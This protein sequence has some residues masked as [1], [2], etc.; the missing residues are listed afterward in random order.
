MEELVVLEAEVVPKPK[1]CTARRGYGEEIV[2]SSRTSIT[3]SSTPP[4]HYSKSQTGP[5][6]QSIPLHIHYPPFTIP[7]GVSSICFVSG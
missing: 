5:K 7:K 3:V 1:N 4:P 6:K 2:Q